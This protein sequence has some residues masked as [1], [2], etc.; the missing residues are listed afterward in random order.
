M[1]DLFASFDWHLILSAKVFLIP[2]ILGVIFLVEKKWG[3]VLGGALSGLPLVSGTLMCF[4]VF[5]QT[6]NDYTLSLYGA[7]EGIVALSLMVFAYSKMTYAITGGSDMQLSG[8]ERG[9]IL[10]KSLLIYLVISAI[11]SA[12]QSKLNE[13]ISSNVAVPLVFIAVCG[14]LNF[15]LYKNL[16]KIRPD[17][18]KVNFKFK[19]SIYMM[20]IGTVTFSIFSSIKTFGPAASLIG[21]ISTAPFYLSIV[22]FMTHKLSTDYD[23]L[24]LNEGI[25][26]G[27]FGYL[28]FFSTFLVGLTILHL[29]PEVVVPAAVILTIGSY[30]VYAFKFSTNNKAEVT[31]MSKQSLAP[32]LPTEENLSDISLNSLQ[33]KLLSGQVNEEPVEKTA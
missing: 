16:P 29:A 28:L 12:L 30:L 7:I 27:F 4:S 19:N 23:L 33:E 2:F 21:L 26:M 1:T 3:T 10:L 24:H 18:N 15:F 31:K 17:E 5:H 22:I 32:M 13:L 20:L 6:V 11:F 9:S 8:K 25:L 14:V